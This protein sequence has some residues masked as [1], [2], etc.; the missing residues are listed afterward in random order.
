MLVVLAAAGFAGIFYWRR[1]VQAPKRPVVAAPSKPPKE[2]KERHRRRRGARRLAR[3]E[4]FVASGAPGEAPGGDDR[5]PSLAPSAPEERAPTP[6]A[7]GGA[8]TTEAAPSD[9]FGALSSPT[10]APSGGRRQP[11]ADPEPVKLRP[12]DL[13]MV[14]QGEDSVAGR[15]HAARFFEG[16]GRARAVAGRD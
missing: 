1:Y 3:N 7:P 16:R 8:A 15:E 11:V 10:A 14:W 4:V 12:A 6:L 9:V 5:S 13:K 2:G